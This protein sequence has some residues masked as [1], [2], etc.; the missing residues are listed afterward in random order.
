[1]KYKWPVLI[2]LNLLFVMAAYFFLEGVMSV[3]NRGAPEPSLLYRAYNKLYGG[4]RRSVLK[5]PAVALDHDFYLADENAIF[6]LHD[7]FLAS[8]VLVSNMFNLE[9][10]PDSYQATFQDP[11]FGLRL[12]PDLQKECAQLKSLLYNGLD[13]LAFSADLGVARREAVR[14]FLDKYSFN[15][16]RYRT[17]KEGDRITLPAVRSEKVILVIGDSVGFGIMLNDDETISSLLQRQESRVEY[18]NAC[19]PGADGEDNIRRLRQKLEELGARVTGVIYVHCEN[20]FSRVATPEYI[21]TNLNE[22]LNSHKIKYRVFIYQQFIYRTMPDI[23]R[24]E[25]RELTAFNNLKL[26]TLD[27]ARK[28]G[29]AVVDFYDLVK[30][31]REEKGS[32]LAGFALYL[33][34]CHFSREGTRLVVD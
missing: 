9:K 19:V 23:N 7:D 3:W 34:H 28:N 27:L 30:Q 26:Q 18:V 1:M 29:F 32:L 15:K 10:P 14:N 33:D 17:D 13:P 12:K 8:K 20:D 16:S 31:Y 21:V 22:L 6:A 24:R 5:E 11:V 25:V 4:Y 2:C